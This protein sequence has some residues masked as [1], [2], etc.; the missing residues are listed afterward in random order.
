M[1]HHAFTR[2]AGNSR[3]A[4]AARTVPQREKTIT[5]CRQAPRIAVESLVTW[6]LSRVAE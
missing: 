2:M 3:G 6:L 4:T 1:R 5:A